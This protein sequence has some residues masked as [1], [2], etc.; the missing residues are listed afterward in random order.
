M[1]SILRN[2]LAIAALL[3]GS[4]GAMLVAQPAAA[5]DRDFHGDHGQNQHWQGDRRAPQIFELTPSQGARVSE[6]GLTRISARFQDER[7][8]VDQRSVTLR[9]DGRDITGRARVDGND[10]R[11]ADNLRPGRHVA[12]LVVRDHAGNVARRSW[13][14]EVRNDVRGDRLGYGYGR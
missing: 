5:Q 12:D 7:S 13:S 8:G 4:T 2:R 10:V 3:L 14:F 6:R 11:Y 9:V 1:K